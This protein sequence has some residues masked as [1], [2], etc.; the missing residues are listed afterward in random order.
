MFFHALAHTD[1]H[2]RIGAFRDAATHSFWLAGALMLVAAALT[3]L[4][5]MRTR[6]EPPPN[7]RIAVAVAVA[8]GIQPY[9]RA[10]QSL[11]AKL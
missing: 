10:C 1:A 4:L 2:S 11:R 8:P 5:P 7:D 3:F 6:E 9:R